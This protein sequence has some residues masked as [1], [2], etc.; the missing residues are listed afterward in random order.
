MSPSKLKAKANVTRIPIVNYDRC[1]PATCGHVC[2]KFCPLNKKGRKVI[3]P[4]KVSKKARIAS[5][6]CIACGICVNKCPT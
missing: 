4:D 6:K 5:Q 3:Y 1:Q 2:I